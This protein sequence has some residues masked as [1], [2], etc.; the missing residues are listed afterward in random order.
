MYLVFS[1]SATTSDLKPI[2]LP[3][4]TSTIFTTIYTTIFTTIIY[5]TIYTTVYISLYPAIF[6]SHRAVHYIHPVSVCLIRAQFDTLEV[7][8][9]TMILESCDL[10]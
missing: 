3:L 1:L 2:A 5:T 9:K 8:L 10:T 7:V 6:V 4:S